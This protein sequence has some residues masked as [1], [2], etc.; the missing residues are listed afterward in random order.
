MSGFIKIH[1]KLLKWGWYSDPNTFRVFMHLLLAASYEENEF[2]GHK[3]LPGQAVIGRKQLARDLGI[4]EQSVRTALEHLKSTNEITIKATNKFTVVTIENWGKYQVQ[5]C[6]TNQ[7]IN[8]RPN[9]RATN[10][11]P[12]TNHTQEGKKVRNKRN[13]VPPKREWVAEYCQ[14]RGKGIDPDAFMDHYAANNWMVGKTKMKDWEAAVRNW[15]RR[16]NKT[17]K[18]YG[19]PEPPKYKEFKPDPKVDAVQMPEEIRQR[20]EGIF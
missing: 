4:S 15:E 19:Q 6:E 11:Q 7:Q 18:K 3:I 5:E 10:E 17:E 20:L 2:R 14:Q 8:Q 16:A 12:T 13:I 1:R 9:Q